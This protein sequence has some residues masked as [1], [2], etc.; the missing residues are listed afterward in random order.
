MKR[1]KIMALPILA[2]IAMTACKGEQKS[3]VEERITEYTDPNTG[4]IS[5]RDYTL[6]DSLYLLRRF[7]Q[8]SCRHKMP[9]ILKKQYLLV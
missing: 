4:I 7:Y 9:L 3:P 1:L 2:A 6:S 5:L 8:F